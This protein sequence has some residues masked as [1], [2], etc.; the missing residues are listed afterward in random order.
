MLTWSTEHLPA[1]D[2]FDS[3][4]EERAKR[5]FGV[6][7]ELPREKRLGFRGAVSAFQVGGALIAELTAS[8]YRVRRDASDIARAP[9]DAFCISQQIEGAGFLVAGG[10][11]IRVDAGAIVTGQTDLPYE[12][13]PDAQEGFSCRIV[14]L[15]L[16]RVSDAVSVR[17]P[18]ALRPVA[19]SPGVPALFASFLAS[20]LDQ[21][22]HLS[23]PAAEVAVDTLIRLALLARGAGDARGG[24]AREALRMALLD[25]ARETIERRLHQPGLSPALVAAALGISTRQLHVLFEPTGTSFGRHLLA[26]RLA[27][28]RL[29]LETSP[30]AS[31]TDVA[32]ASGFDG[33]STF[34][35]GFRAAYG[36]SPGEVRAQAAR[37]G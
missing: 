14:R 17:E 3:W 7:I 26:R 23:E 13:L 19:P 27:R 35:R 21:A 24:S 6:S 22:P 2:R 8:A 4:R 31:V 5:V 1:Q 12:N 18:F 37:E 15:P 25:R 34:F 30:R 32:L 16:S 9:S 33:L 11:E 28:A 10:R 36:C 29:I 20:F